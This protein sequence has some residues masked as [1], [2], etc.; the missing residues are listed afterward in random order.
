MNYKITKFHVFPNLKQINNKRTL[1]NLYKVI[2]L[3]TRLHIF[4]TT[5]FTINNIKIVVQMH[6]F[7]FYHQSYLMYINH[8]HY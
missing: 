4:S 2:V 1:V 7:Q 3:V 8:K 5:L 6:T